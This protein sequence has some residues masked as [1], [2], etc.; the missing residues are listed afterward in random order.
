EARRP[1]L[2]DAHLAH[3]EGQG[4]DVILVGVRE[5]DGADGAVAEVAE[6]GKDDVDAEVLVARERHPRVDDDDLVAELE[7]RH[8]LADLAEAAERNDAKAVR[9]GGGAYAATRSPRRSR[10]PRTR[11]SS[12]SVGSTSGSRYPPT[13]CPSSR[14]AALIGIGFVVTASS[15]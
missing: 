2:L 10:H 14:R 7:H 12:S 3:E 4:A 1:D 5:D 9:H 11:S 8:V 15:S 13:G 6:V